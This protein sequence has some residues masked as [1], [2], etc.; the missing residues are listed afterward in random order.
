MHQNNIFLIFLKIN[1]EI[2]ISKQCKTYKKNNFLKNT[3]WSVFPNRLINR[4]IRVIFFLSHNP[5]KLQVERAKQK[6]IIME[7]Y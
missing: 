4:R 2:N 5:R 6:I 7:M 3:G 1:F